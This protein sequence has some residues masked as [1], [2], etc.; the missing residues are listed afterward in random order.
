MTDNYQNQEQDRRIGDLER[1]V[2]VVFGHIA[3]TNEEMGQ[4]KT[5]VSWLTRF[6]WIVATA[7]I[8]GLIA[9]LLN[10]IVTINK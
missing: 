4:I 10:L 7:S 5:D 9:A 3:K 8:G 2:E 1:K 6:F